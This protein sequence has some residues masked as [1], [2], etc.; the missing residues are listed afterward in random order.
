MKFVQSCVAVV[1]KLQEGGKK[2]HVNEQS[3]QKEKL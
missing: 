1:H 3:A 2:M